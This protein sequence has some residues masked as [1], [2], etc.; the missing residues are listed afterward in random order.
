VRITMNRSGR[1][2]ANSTSSARVSSLNFR[3]TWALAP[4]VP[5]ELRR[6]IEELASPPL[7]GS[8]RPRTPLRGGRQP[9][10]WPRRSRC[11]WARRIPA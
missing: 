6:Q 10:D 2:R 7:N 5:T 3:M 8:P 4:D 9:A 11:T 1:W